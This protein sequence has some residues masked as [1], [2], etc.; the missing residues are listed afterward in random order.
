MASARKGAA[1]DRTTLKVEGVVD[2][3]V[4]DAAIEPCRGGKPPLPGRT[5]F[6][7]DALHHPDR[8]SGHHG[9]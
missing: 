3:G 4:H 9:R 7:P 2:G 1:G 8:F 5:S 6:M